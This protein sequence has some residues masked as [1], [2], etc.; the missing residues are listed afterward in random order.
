MDKLP[1]KS[2]Q[3]NLTNLKI[4]KKNTTKNQITE[5]TNKDILLNFFNLTNNTK[6]TCFHKPKLNHVYILQNKYNINYIITLQ[7]IEENPKA[8]VKLL[9]AY[10]TYK[11]EYKHVKL[12]GANSSLLF[13]KDTMIMLIENI[14]EIYYKIKE[15]S[16]NKDLNILVHCSAGIH[17]TGITLYVLL[18]LFCFNEKEAMEAIQIIRIETYKGVGVERIKFAEELYNKIKKNI[19]N[20]EEN[21]K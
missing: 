13:N 18:R 2:N 4:H 3:T 16:N 14:T 9:N 20:I 19:E 7:G 15:F 21:E 8:L 10:D 5:D 17:R 11:I 1:D 12:K 6:L